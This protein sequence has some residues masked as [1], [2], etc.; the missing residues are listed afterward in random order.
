MVNETTAQETA[1]AIASALPDPEIPA[2]TIAEL[3]I[4]RSVELMEGVITVSIT[5]TYSG[6]PATEMIKGDIETAL[7]DAGF[8]AVAVRLIHSPAWTTDTLSAATLEKLRAEGIAPPH[9]GQAPHCPLCGSSAVEQVAAFGS[10]PCKSLWRCITCR[11]PFDHFKC[12]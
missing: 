8:S 7:R 6:C 5:P 1:W 3:G 12:H 10:T 4:L 9:R 2:L 11:E